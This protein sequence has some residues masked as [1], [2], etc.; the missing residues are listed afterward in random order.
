MNKR[1]IQYFF[2]AAMLLFFVAQVVGAPGDQKFPVSSGRFERYSQ[3]V[4]GQFS[5]LWARPAGSGS[6]TNLSSY[7]R[8]PH[9]G[10]L[11]THW[12]AGVFRADQLVSRFTNHSGATYPHLGAKDK[13][14]FDNRSGSTISYNGVSNK[15]YIQSAK[16]PAPFAWWENG[17]RYTTNYAEISVPTQYAQTYLYFQNGTLQASTTPW[18][19]TGTAAPIATA[20]RVGSSAALA[21]ER[22]NASRDRFLHAMLHSSVGARWSSGLSCSFTNTAFSCGSGVIYDEDLSHLI[23][24][25]TSGRIWYGG[26]SSQLR[27]QLSNTTP[28]YAIGGVLYYDNAGTPAPVGTNKY[29]ANY[30]YA[31]NE[32][33]GY[34]PIN[35]V[36]GQAQYNTAA[37]ARSSTLPLMGN[38]TTREW[39]LLYRVIYQN[40]GGSP[41]YIE[42]ADYREASSLPGGSTSSMSASNVIFSQYTTT[43]RWSNVQQAITETNRL[44]PVVCGTDVSTAIF[45]GAPGAPA[46]FCN[47]SGGVRSV[48]YDSNGANPLPSLSAFVAQLWE[49]GTRVVATAWSWITGGSSM[50][51]Y[52]S[53]TSSSFTPSVKSA[54]SAY[55]SN[56]YVAVQ[57][58]Y[59]SI[60]GRRYCRTGVPIAVSKVGPQGSIG[61]TGS[62]ATLA[63]GTTTTVSS[64]TPASATFTGTSTAR[65]L[66]LWLPKGADGD[67][68][69]ISQSQIFDKID[70]ASTGILARRTNSADTD[71]MFKIMDLASNT[72]LYVTSAGM[73]YIL[74]ANGKAR[75]TFNTT[76]NTLKLGNYSTASSRAGATIDSLGQITTYRSNG[77]TKAF[78]TFTSGRIQL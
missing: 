30:I 67:P 46:L 63:M 29:V 37:E 62:A 47:I 4:H 1:I 25:T 14:G 54:F 57:L 13:S 40:F 6:F 34:F 74:D 17:Q 73:L 18:D 68:G 66:N 44:M 58:T 23:G 26:S 64:T 41:K 33:S 36:T 10:N 43:R 48:V 39:K 51:I 9:F 27:F 32:P 21:D 35:I 45:D 76:S 65:V 69:A 8:R 49:S 60:Y 15:F 19:I 53:G 38:M 3:S 5:S 16:Y 24:D 12:N 77:T 31:T 42:A 28:Y 61:A 2:A 59:S 20:Y 70:D 75:F 22:H 56:N 72:R 78:Q 71:T 55:S 52:G 7:V 11:S 50:R